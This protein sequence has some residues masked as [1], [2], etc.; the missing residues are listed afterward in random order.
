M[1]YDIT[2]VTGAV[3]KASVE[4]GKRIAFTYAVE[5]HFKFKN[6]AELRIKHEIKLPVFLWAV[7]VEHKHVAVDHECYQDTNTDAID[8]LYFTQY[9][10]V[11]QKYVIF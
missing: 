1:S 9:F 8:I 4:W 7:I 3:D 5:W 11:V 2:K 6:M 10:I